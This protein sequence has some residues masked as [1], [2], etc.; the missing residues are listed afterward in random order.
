MSESIECPKCWGTGWITHDAH[1]RECD[2]TGEVPA[3]PWCIGADLLY[4][5]MKDR[6]AEDR[7]G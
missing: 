7:D 5:E 1:C 3:D 2:G 6:K 4:D